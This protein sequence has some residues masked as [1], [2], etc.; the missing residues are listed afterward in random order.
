MLKRFSAFCCACNV[1]A[2]I[3]ALNVDLAKEVPSLLPESASSMDRPTGTGSIRPGGEPGVRVTAAQ[4]TSSGPEPGASCRICGR[5]APLHSTGRLIHAYP[6]KYCGQCGTVLV[7]NQPSSAEVRKLYDS[8]FADGEYEQHRV[9]F[10]ML[11][12]GRRPRN[13]ERRRLLARIERTCP[14]RTLVEIGGG[15]GKFGVEATRRGWRYTNYDVSETA[16]RFC[17][18]LGLNARRFEPGTAP[19]LEPESTSVV[20]MWEVIEHVWNVRE[21]LDTIRNALRPGGIFLLSTPN[22]LTPALFKQEDWGP[23]SSPP[24]HLNFF[25]KASLERTLRESRFRE[26]TVFPRRLYAPSGGFG[27]WLRSLRFALLIDECET[28]YAIATKSA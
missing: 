24:I 27:G 25:T 9:E 7:E 22:Y 1:A 11:K 17:R 15:T 19:P 12:S 20:V 5:E 3:C 6:L 23:L 21:Y 8:L 14:D 18:E 13:F 4:V 10:E 16:V 2:S 28:L 26:V